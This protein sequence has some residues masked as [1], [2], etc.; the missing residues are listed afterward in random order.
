MK[1]NLQLPV[2]IWDLLPVC[3]YRNKGEVENIFFY[4]HSIHIPALTI[5][6][7]SCSLSVV[8]SKVTLRINVVQTTTGPVCSYTPKKRKHW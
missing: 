1:H 7:M 5:R 3:Y 2:S 6:T 4:A 8:T